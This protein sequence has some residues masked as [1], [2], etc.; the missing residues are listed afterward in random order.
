MK[1]V[2]ALFLALMVSAGAQAD[3]LG[4]A[5]NLVGKALDKNVSVNSSVGVLNDSSLD[6][7][8]TAKDGGTAGAGGAVA[9]QKIGSGFISVNSAVGV[10]NNSNVKAKANASGQGSQANAGGAVAAQ[11]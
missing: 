6:A 3:S 10:L 8:A 1:K 7:E 11:Q 2:S 5:A 9:S 4:Q